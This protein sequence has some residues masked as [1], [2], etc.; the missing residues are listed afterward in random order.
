MHEMQDSGTQMQSYIIKPAHLVTR[1]MCHPML[2]TL[3][4]QIPFCLVAL[5]HKTK[6]M[7]LQGRHIDLV[8][9][10]GYLIFLQ[11]SGTALLAFDQIIAG[12]TLPGV[13]V[14]AEEP[15]EGRLHSMVQRDEL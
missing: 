9:F 2:P 8:V 4:L 13:V 5:T 11:N 1:R 7:S 3:F 10:L 15:L 12:E 6:L 14:Y